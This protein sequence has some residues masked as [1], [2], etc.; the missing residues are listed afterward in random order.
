MKI[1][2]S[3]DYD[4]NIHDASTIRR[5]MRNL[6]SSIEALEGR[7]NVRDLVVETLYQNDGKRPQELIEELHTI[8]DDATEALRQL[9]EVKETLSLLGEELLEYRTVLL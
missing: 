6:L 4:L 3:T 1:Y 7:I 5:E 2:E 9:Q 8:L